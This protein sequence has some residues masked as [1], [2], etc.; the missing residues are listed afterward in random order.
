MN[1][2]KIIKEISQKCSISLKIKENFITHIYILDCMT[3][4]SEN[5]H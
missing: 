3:F 1:K 4:L 2:V 5:F